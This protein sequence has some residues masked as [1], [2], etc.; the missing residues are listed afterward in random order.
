MKIID[1]NEQVDAEALQGIN[2]F[3]VGEQDKKVATEPQV[4]LGLRMSII[5]LDVGEY[6]IYY[7]NRLVGSSKNTDDVRIAVENLMLKHGAELEN[8][9]L[10]KR[11]PIDF[12][13]FL[14]E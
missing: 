10:Y 14:R 7:K 9:F 1:N 4:D 12:G 2:Q 3:S 6:V 8:I 11:I 5:E 13:V